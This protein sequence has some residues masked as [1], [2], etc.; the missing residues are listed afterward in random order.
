MQNCRGIGK[1]IRKNNAKSGTMKISE[2][3][4]RNYKVTL[5]TGARIAV[6]FIIVPRL[7]QKSTSAPPRSIISVVS[8]HNKTAIRAPVTKLLF[9]PY[10]QICHLY[11]PIS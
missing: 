2:E 6:I 5:V 3:K 11:V 8:V 10:L 9:S 4:I 7:T 1:S